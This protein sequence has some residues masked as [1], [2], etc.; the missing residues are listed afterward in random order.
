MENYRIGI[1]GY[2]GFGKFLHHWFD[3][4][5]NAKVVAIA[6]TGHRTHDIPDCKVYYDWKELLGDPEIDIVSIVTPPGLHAEMACEAMKAGKHVLLEK[7]VAITEETAEEILKVQQETGKIITVNHMIRY[8]PIMQ[9]VKELGESGAFGELRHVVVNNYAQD[10]A[11][12]LEHW[13]WNEEMSGGILVEHGVHFFDIVN[14]LTR[15]KFK[16]VF[17]T[18]HHRNSEQRDRV[19]AMVL[20]D[21][22]MIGSYY[23]AFSGPGMF[24]QTTIQLA[25]DLARIEIEGW[26][27]LKGKIHAMVN[28][29]TKAEIGELPGWTMQS[30]ESLESSEDSSR[31]EGWGSS[32]YSH[33]TATKV[34][35]GI[36]YPVDEVMTGTFEIHESKGEV[37]GKCVQSILNDLIQKIENK[38]HK[39]QI[40][41]EDG[42]LAL[43]I[44]L[45]ASE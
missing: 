36:A 10:E 45:L 7:P 25:Y 31:P 44:A 35:A 9:K 8:N 1:I 5:E 30:G 29:M 16:Q 4:M 34:F 43:K 18:S 26:M 22:G 33:D 41:I 27:P 6:E 11:L 40:T 28:D 19:A 20:Y 39:L 17:G 15:Q 14:S 32:E 13:F 23:H 42:V 3:K 21:D 38:D 37:Y 24:E 2:G 12:P